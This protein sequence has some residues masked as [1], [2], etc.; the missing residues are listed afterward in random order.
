[1]RTAVELDFADGVYLFDLKLPQIAELQEKCDAGIFR[2]YGRVM[3]GRGTI[4]GL[5]IGLPEHGEAFASD[6]FETIRLGL[7]GG[8]EGIVDGAAIKVSPGIAMKLVERYC[9]NAPLRDSWALAAAILM[10][11]IEGYNP[12]KKAEPDEDPASQGT[13][14]TSAE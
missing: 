8:A 13:I 1:M 10:A 2:I 12:P 4:E 11:R 9:H 5:P 6:L 14:S 7:I 3:L